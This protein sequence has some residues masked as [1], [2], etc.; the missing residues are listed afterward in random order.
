MTRVVVY[1][2]G[3]REDTAVCSWQKMVF[4]AFKTLKKLTSCFQYVRSCVRACVHACRLVFKEEVQYWNQC[5]CVGPR[6]STLGTIASYCLRLCRCS[7]QRCLR[8]FSHT[9][10]ATSPARFWVKLIVCALLACRHDGARCRRKANK[11][12]IVTTN[13]NLRP[14]PPPPPSPTRRTKG[15]FITHMG[16]PPAPETEA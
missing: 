10:T 14:P 15:T 3:F 11:I 8:Y 9:T 16:P 2:L 1:L 4:V 6:G 12:I 7:L 13:Q 5:S